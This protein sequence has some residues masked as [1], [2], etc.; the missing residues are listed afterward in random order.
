M[1]EHQELD[2]IAR[3]RVIKASIEMLRKSIETLKN[4]N[5]PVKDLDDKIEVIEHEIQDYY[6]VA[7][8]SFGLS[9]AALDKLEYAT[10]VKPEWEEKYKE[11]EKRL[12]EKEEKKNATVKQSTIVNQKETKKY[13][14]Q[15]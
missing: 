1:A 12:H 5:P 8:N 6:K 4:M 13:G 2:N 9:P 10:Q 7:Q 3:A 15:K 14:F 11:I